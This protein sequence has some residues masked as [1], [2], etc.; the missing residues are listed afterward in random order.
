MIPIEFWREPGRSAPGLTRSRHRRVVCGEHLGPHEYNNG[1]VT[2]QSKGVVLEKNAL[3]YTCR[4]GFIDLAHVRDNADLTLF[5]ATRIARDLP[6]GSAFDLPEDGA[7]RRVVVRPLPPELVLKL[8]RTETAVLIAA[9]LAF[10]LS[11]W[12]E[13]ITWYGAESVPGFSERVS[14]FSPED[15]YSNVVGIRLAMG[16]VR[17][18]LART[19]DGYNHAVDAWIA[20]GLRRLG[21]VQHDAAKAAM[22]RVDGVWWDSRKTVRDFALVR[23]R[24]V[25]IRPPIAPWLAPDACPG[26]AAHPLDLPER[27][28]DLELAGLA[29]IAFSVEDKLLRDFPLP[30]AVERPLTIA[31]YPALEAA[32]RR[33]GAMELGPGF[34][35]PEPQPAVA[36]GVPIL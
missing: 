27:V 26:I 23:R 34:D 1:L 16:I 2:F 12:H 7:R 19:R 17:A 36:R 13:F 33:D 3:V 6:G 9:Y 15:L 31:D 8:G 30:V 21:A 14:A 29:T 5:L 35:R 28:G 10:R 22:A 25:A 4:G 18:N 20:A 32:V 11:V 24:H